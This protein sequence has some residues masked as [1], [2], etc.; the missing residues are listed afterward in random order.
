VD[1]AAATSA[2]ARATD[3]LAEAEEPQA[4][5]KFHAEGLGGGAALGGAAGGGDLE[6]EA[7]VEEQ[8]PPDEE[9]VGAAA[10]PRRKRKIAQLDDSEEEEASDGLLGQGESRQLLGQGESRQLGRHGSVRLA[11]SSVPIVDRGSVFTAQVVW[12][13]HSAEA[14]RAAMVLM[15][16][17][18][19]AAGADHNMTAFRVREEGRVQ[20]AYEDDGEAGGGYRLMSCLARL[21]GTDVAIMVSRVYGG[22]NLGPIRFDHISRVAEDLLAE[23]QHQPDKG[24][25][26]SAGSGQPTGGA[27]SAA[28]GGAGGGAGSS[29]VAGRA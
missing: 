16:G 5:R 8:P 20:Q 3:A 24:I 1:S 28:G 15:R 11:R 14:A 12:P 18:A 26:P 4:R 13:V 22:R 27:R 10:K 21:R 25:P 29:A 23:L 6:D 9:L 7:F 2:A 19:P 17:E